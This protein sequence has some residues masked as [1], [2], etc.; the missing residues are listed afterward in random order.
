MSREH[1]GTRTQLLAKCES[2]RYRQ[3][4]RRNLLC[5]HWPP[6]RLV[7]LSLRRLRS[8]PLVALRVLHTKGFLLGKN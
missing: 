3:G 4:G 7:T 5:D 8:S 2:K 1:S 6:V